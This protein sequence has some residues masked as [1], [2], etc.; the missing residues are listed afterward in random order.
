MG[1]LV[2]FDTR[3]KKPA[4]WNAAVLTGIAAVTA[5]ILICIGDEKNSLLLCL[6]MDLYLL[7]LITFL[8]CAFFKQLQ[9]NPYSYN[10]IIYTGFSFFCC[11]S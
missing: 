9:Y 6:L 5:F 11:L 1:K 4:L 10:T 3:D 2:K 8:V 7:V